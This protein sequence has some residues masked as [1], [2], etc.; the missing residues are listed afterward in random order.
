MRN[1]QGNI[2]DQVGIVNAVCVTTNGI[3]KRDG[4]LVM[5]AGIA[6]EAVKKYPSI[7][8]TFGG[9]VKKYGNIPAIG[10]TDRDT[11]IVSFPTKNDY[12]DPSDIFL[13]RRSAESLK[14]MADIHNWKRIALP[15]PGCG[16]GG[17]D[18]IDVQKI[19]NPILDD[20]FEIWT[21]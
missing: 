11:N 5:G 4:S 9:I 15:R 6:L 14:I 13:I 18:W 7:Q 3:V 20:R 16:L 21:F 10:I 1:R 17:L 2:W 8:Y 19:L 12:E